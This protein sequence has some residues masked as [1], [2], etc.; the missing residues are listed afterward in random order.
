MA[1]DTGDPG[2]LRTSISGDLEVSGYLGAA[3][4]LDLRPANEETQQAR[5]EAVVIIDFGSQYSRLIAR[6]VRECNVYCEILAHD[7]PWERV[8]DLHP[9]GCDPV[10]RPRQRL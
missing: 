4:G 7:V 2:P 8:A 3:E 1:S 9:E 10:R 5:G 6:R